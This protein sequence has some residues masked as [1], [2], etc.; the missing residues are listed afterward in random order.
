MQNSYLSWQADCRPLSYF[1]LHIYNRWGMEMQHIFSPSEFWIPGPQD[2]RDDYYWY[3]RYKWEEGGGD[4][5][6]AK[7]EIRYWR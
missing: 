3:L 5:L 1:D 4:T 2:Q 7:G 6:T